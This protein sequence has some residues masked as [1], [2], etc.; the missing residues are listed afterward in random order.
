[1]HQNN[2]IA[3]IFTGFVTRQLSSLIQDITWPGFSDLPT[4]TWTNIFT[5]L[6]IYLGKIVACRLLFLQFLWAHGKCYTQH[7][8]EWK[9]ILNLFCCSFWLF[10]EVNLRH[11]PV[12]QMY[13][14]IYSTGKT[15]N[16]ED[17]FIKDTWKLLC[18]G[19]LHKE[20]TQEIA[21]NWVITPPWTCHA[22]SNFTLPLS[23]LFD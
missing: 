15:A 21:S 4:I 22:F 8:K 6:I 9:G 5:I 23:K 17:K 1:M 14:S 11:S 2:K 12:C 20:Y 18:E 13:Q 7:N 16:T 3:Y 19:C 10:T